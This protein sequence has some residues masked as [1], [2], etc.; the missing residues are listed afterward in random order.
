M[1]GE[2][3]IS[4]LSTHCLSPIPIIHGSEILTPWGECL[5]FGQDALYAYF[6]LKR[7][8]WTH[9]IR[10]HGVYEPMLDLLPR[11]MVTV[12]DLPD[13]PAPD[14]GAV[15]KMALATPERWLEEFSSRVQ[16]TV[17]ALVLCHPSHFEEHKCPEGAADAY[18]KFKPGFKQ[19]VKLLHG[20]EVQNGSYRFQGI[21][22]LF[23]LMR[24]SARK[25]HNS[26]AHSADSLDM[27]ANETDEPVR[28]EAELIRWLGG[29]LE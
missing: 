14:E 28:D 24:P 7:D 5:L 13:V 26:D 10:E 16:N 22:W 12:F 17:H 4:M 11:A 1:M 27:C 8:R 19:F 29:N 21:E 18:E 6:G 15:K 23:D 25:L 20:V 9:R 3:I 2:Y